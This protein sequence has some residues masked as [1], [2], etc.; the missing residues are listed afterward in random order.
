M[1]G[2]LLECGGGKKYDSKNYSN[3]RFYIRGRVR[4]TLWIIF[5]IANDNDITSTKLCND[6]DECIL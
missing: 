6:K 3:T 2:G 1:V 5:M 4:S